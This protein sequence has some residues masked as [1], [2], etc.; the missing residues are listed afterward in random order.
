M[1]LAIVLRLNRGTPTGA[2]KLELIENLNN[3]KYKWTYIKKYSIL[4]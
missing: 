4:L 2:K 3:Q 1:G